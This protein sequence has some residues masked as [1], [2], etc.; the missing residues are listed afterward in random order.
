MNRQVNVASVAALRRFQA[1]L[2]DYAESVQEVLATLVLETQHSVDWV[3]T[4]RMAH[5]PS[6]VRR[7]SD[8][9]IESLNRLERKQ[10]TV[11]RGDPPSCTEEKEAVQVSRQR[12]RM[13]EE[14]VA[15]TRRWN[16]KIHHQADEY[17]GVSAKLSYI[18]ETQLPQASSTLDRMASALEKYVQSANLETT[19][20]SAVRSGD[21]RSPT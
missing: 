17:R 8:A 13:C 14:K 4:D 18:A 12:L 7:A 16:H 3:E 11:D 15:A 1:A 21:E 10:L 20:G 19:D 2:R 9:L 5:W 6:E